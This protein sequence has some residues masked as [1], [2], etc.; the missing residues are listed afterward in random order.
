MALRG[1][2]S[3]QPPPIISRIVV[4]IAA[5][6]LAIEDHVLGLVTTMPILEALVSRHR[7]RGPG[8]L[9]VFLTDYSEVAT[10]SALGSARSAAFSLVASSTQ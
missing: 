2:L 1:I 9:S 6:N 5:A 4:I 7:V 10:V 3:D 8:C